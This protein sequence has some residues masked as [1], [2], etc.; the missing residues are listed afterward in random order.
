MEN[1]ILFINSLCGRLGSRHF[2][3]LTFADPEQQGPHFQ[4]GGYFLEKRL[5]GNDDNGPS[6]PNPIFDNA[7]NLPLSYYF[8]NDYNVDNANW[9]NTNSFYEYPSP[10]PNSYWPSATVPYSYPS[11]P[12]PAPSNGYYNQP[13]P[14]SGPQTPYQYGYFY[15]PLELV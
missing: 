8:N 15:Y 13:M 11:P 14:I 6:Q 4:N 3:P 2:D 12:M 9:Q 10:D 1:A 5:Y 7:A